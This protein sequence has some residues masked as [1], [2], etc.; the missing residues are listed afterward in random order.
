MGICAMERGQ[1]QESFAG[2]FVIAKENV[3]DPLPFRS[4]QPGSD[5]SITL[6]L[7]RY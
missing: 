6:V 7:R 5:E 1:E 3:C 4:R 2:R